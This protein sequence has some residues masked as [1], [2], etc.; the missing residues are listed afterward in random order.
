MTLLWAYLADN[1]LNSPFEDIVNYLVTILMFLGM[2]FTGMLWAV[3]RE[4]PQGIMLKGRPA[5]IVGLTLCILSWF[6]ALY[7]L[8]LLVVRFFGI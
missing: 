8:L 6:F 1:Y 5:V 7:A 2:G 3:R 4:A